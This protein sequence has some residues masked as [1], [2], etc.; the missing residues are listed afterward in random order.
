MSTPDTNSSRFQTVRRW[1]RVVGVTL[2]ELVM[3]IMVVSV[4][5]AGIL[6][7][8]TYTA[9]HSADPMVQQQALLVAEAYMQEILLKP[10]LDPDGGTQT[11]PAPEANRGAFDNVCDY[12][13]LNDA[14]ARDQLNNAI[15]GLEQY[16]VAVAVSGGPGLSL[17]PA[18]D[19]VA[20]T[21]SVRVLRVDVTV[22]HSQTPIDLIL[23][24]YR[25][26][27]NCSTTGSPA[28]RGL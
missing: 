12:N 13:G 24:G 2:V 8:M 4:G 28:C 5:V 3:Y 16:N 9:R 14:G 15:S 25:T 19:L 21:A 7:V 18:A 10:F 26:S 11:C 1:R 27:Y 17:G 6:S 20:N 22:T 23:T